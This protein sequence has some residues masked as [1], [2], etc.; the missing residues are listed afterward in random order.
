MTSRFPLAPRPGF[1]PISRRRLLAGIGASVT[2]LAVPARS[3]AAGEMAPKAETA[4]D[5]FHVLHARPGEAPLRGPNETPT[6]IWGYDGMSPGPL[7][8]VKQGE[9]LKVRLINDLKQDTVIHWHGLRLPN[10][11]DGVPFL[12]QKPVAPGASFDYAFTP[13]DA[14]TFWYHTHFGS[15]EQLARGL[16]GVLIVDEPEPPEVDRDLVMVVD[17]WRLTDDGTIQPS[18]GNFHDA[19]MAGRLGQYI[20]LNSEDFLDAHGEDQR[21]YPAA[22]REHRQFAH[23]PACAST[24][25]AARVMAVDGQPCPPEFAPDGVLRLAPGTRIDLFL[26]ATLEPGSKAPILVDDLRGGWL[27]VGQSRLRRRRA[28]ARPL[29]C[30]SRGRCRPIRCRPSSISPMPSSSTCRST[31]AAWP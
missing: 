15:T 30:P 3:R 25:H 23:F 17:D 14:G 9:P 31:A 22:H 1:G 10:A 16:Y 7:L 29:R 4:A 28:G 5:G 24:K 12:T 11:M 18:F 13:P 20:T 2:L 19:M 26:D 8:R 21:A 6:P 27:Q